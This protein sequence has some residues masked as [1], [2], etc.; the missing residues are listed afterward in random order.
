MP[1]VVGA[2]DTER[3]SGGWATGEEGEGEGMSGLEG[4]SSGEETSDSWSSSGV[5]A[6][7]AIVQPL[8]LAGRRGCVS[9]RERCDAEGG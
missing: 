8:Q 1:E 5:E 4:D 9:R 2:V 7:I 3:P 6:A